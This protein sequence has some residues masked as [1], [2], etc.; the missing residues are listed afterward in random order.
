MI[1]PQEIPLA[2]ARGAVPDLFALGREAAAAA[3][4][5]TGGRGVFAR[6]RQ[7]LGSGAW[8]GPR[9]AAD[10]YVE[11]DAL[12]ALGGLEAAVAAGA[13]ILIASSQ[14]SPLGQAGLRP[15][16]QTWGPWDGPQP[17]PRRSPLGQAELRPP[18]SAD[19]R[20]I[21]RLSYRAGEPD[22]AREARLLAARRLPVDGVLPTPDGEPL[23][24]DTLHFVALCRLRL[25][26][27]HV[28]VDFARLGHRLA[29]M[30]L[31]FGGDELHGPI[32]SERALR[33]GDNAG[34]PAATR[35]EAATLIRGAGWIP[36]ERTAG[37]VLTPFEER[38]P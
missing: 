18:G 26:V 24:L 5:L 6:S 38:L 25:S 27:P 34:N 33:L 13:R 3:R 14:R 35:R 2:E 31:A 11:E 22:A 23:G 15:P 9:D 37:G 30:C 36:H 21:L 16:D 4:A 20:V 10:A 12:P 19:L 8:R 32:V 7:L 29:Q 28:V 1:V 17:L